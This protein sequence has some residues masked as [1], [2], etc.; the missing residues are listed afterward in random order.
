MITEDGKVDTAV[1]RDRAGGFRAA[2]DRQT[3]DHFTGFDAKILSFYACGMTLRESR[4]TRP[5]CMAWT[6]RPRQMCLTTCGSGTTVE[7]A[8]RSGPSAF[9]RD[10]AFDGEVRPCQ[11]APRFDS[12]ENRLQKN[13]D[14]PDPP[15]QRGPFPSLTA[16]PVWRLRSIRVFLT[17]V[18]GGIAWSSTLARVPQSRPAASGSNTSPEEYDIH[19]R[20]NSPLPFGNLSGRHLRCEAS[21]SLC[22]VPNAHPRLMIHRHSAIRLRQSTGHWPTNQRDRLLKYG[23]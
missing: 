13:S 12:H 17:I 8:A 21:V 23:L 15:S 6:H 16:G 5:G 22:G 18:S 1:P 7:P 14:I 11:D 9:V 20:A 19:R 2:V 10:E 4:G 3:P